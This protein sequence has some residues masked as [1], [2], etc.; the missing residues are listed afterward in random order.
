MTPLGLVS[1]HTQHLLSYV[2]GYKELVSFAR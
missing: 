2:L 1:G